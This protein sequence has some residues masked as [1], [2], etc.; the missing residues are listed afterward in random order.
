MWLWGLSGSSAGRVL[1]V[2]QPP[3]VLE[4]C[5][6][7]SFA[8]WGSYCPSIFS[9]AWTS[10]PAMKQQAAAHA[11]CLLMHEALG[12]INFADAA[13][14]P[15]QGMNIQM[16]HE[17]SCLCTRQLCLQEDSQTGLRAQQ[18]G[19]LKAAF[20]LCPPAKSSSICILDS[21]RKPL[22]TSP[23][24]SPNT[25]CTPTHAQNHLEPA[26]QTQQ[27]QPPSS[28]PSGSLRTHFILTRAQDHL[29]PAV[30]AG[31]ATAEPWAAAPPGGPAAQP[32]LAHHQPQQRPGPGSRRGRRGGPVPSP[33]SRC[34]LVNCG[35]DF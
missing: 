14:P 4:G 16:E 22:T 13:Q 15:K 27:A 32:A 30:R 24:T 34:R 31:S 11:C 9:S 7:A 21:L 19:A 12:D 23:S 5:S 17:R 8:P 26:V 29:Q 18:S 28:S 10:A 3:A 1:E 20:N 2:P 25:Q 35:A 6:N 33:D